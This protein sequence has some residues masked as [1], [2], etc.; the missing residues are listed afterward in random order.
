MKIPIPV[1]R[2]VRIEII[3]LIDIVFFLLATF[4]MV[5]LTM[6]K[7]ESVPVHLPTAKTSVS[8]GIQNTVTLTIK[9]NGDVFFNKDKVVGDQLAVRLKRMNAQTPDLQVMINGDEKASF[10][11]AV[12]VLDAVRRLKIAKVSIRTRGHH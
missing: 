8:V 5:S 12:A 2:C 4:A 11:Q 6:V 10:G 9:E 1:K 3:P 7:N